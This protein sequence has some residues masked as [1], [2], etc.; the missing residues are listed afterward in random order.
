M[1]GDGPRSAA[2][3]GERADHLMTNE[4]VLARHRRLPTCESLRRWMRSRSCLSLAP[5]VQDPDS[6]MCSVLL[7][8][9]VAETRVKAHV[10]SMLLRLG[11]Q[12]RVQVVVAAHR[13]CLGH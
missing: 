10:A 13:S 3:S 11:V 4:G 5:S 9:F 1:T 8:L 7:A 12:A 2:T 6:R